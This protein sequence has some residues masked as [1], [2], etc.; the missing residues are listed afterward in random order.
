MHDPGFTIDIPPDDP[1]FSREHRE[2]ADRLSREIVKRKLAIPALVLLEF[3]QPLRELGAE[4][5]R[6]LAPFLEILRPEQD[7]LSTEQSE[8]AH[9]K[10]AELLRSPRAVEYLCQQIDELE[11]ERRL[12][13]SA[14]NP[15]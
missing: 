3:S 9:R 8:P 11:K 14:L 12:Q 15:E 10:L 1:G 4:A 2:L 7:A 5:M 6:F 13:E